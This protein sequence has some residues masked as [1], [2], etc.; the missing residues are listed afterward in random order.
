MLIMYQALFLCRST[1]AIY[2]M[3]GVRAHLLDENTNQTLCVWYVFR[4]QSQLN[5]SGGK[6]HEKH[7]W[8]PF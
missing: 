7:A 8:E 6:V 4:I 3:R 5:P 1:G 2:Y